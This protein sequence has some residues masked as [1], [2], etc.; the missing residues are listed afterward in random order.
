MGEVRDKPRTHAPSAHM[1]TA[2]AAGTVPGHGAGAAGVSP[3]GSRLRRR[4]GCVRSRVHA[5]R[6]GHV[7]RPPAPAHLAHE[8]RDGGPATVAVVPAPRRQQVGHAPQAS[9]GAGGRPDGRHGQ[10]APGAR[11]TALE[12]RAAPG[13]ALLPGHAVLPAVFHGRHRVA[14]GRRRHADRRDLRTGATPQR[15]GCHRR[16]TAARRVP[17]AG[18]HDE[19][20]RGEARKPPRG[21]AAGS[22]QGSAQR[23][24]L[25]PGTMALGSVEPWL[26]SSNSTQQRARTHHQQRSTVASQRR[27]QPT[28]P[29]QQNRREHRRQQGRQSRGPRVPSPRP[30]LSASAPTHH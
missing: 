24:R 11:H 15:A 7:G 25:A 1:R 10:L 22:A 4:G 12:P 29:E 27:Q 3:R 19:R 13:Q 18:Q 28:K 9:R 30:S 16:R 8:G 26:S 6:P 20:R 14:G 5:P 17:Q 2:T 21:G 23:A